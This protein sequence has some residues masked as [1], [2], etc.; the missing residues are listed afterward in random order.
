MNGAARDSN[1]RETKKATGGRE[2]GRWLSDRDRLGLR[3]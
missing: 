3:P 1:A 2:D